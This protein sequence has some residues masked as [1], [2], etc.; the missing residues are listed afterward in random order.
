MESLL[1][2]IYPAPCVR[3]VLGRLQE[4]KNEYGTSLMLRGQIFELIL[5]IEAGK[6]ELCLPGTENLREIKL[7]RPIDGGH[8]EAQELVC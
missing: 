8:S 1:A 2:F 5:E 7:H 3:C 6:Y 4:S